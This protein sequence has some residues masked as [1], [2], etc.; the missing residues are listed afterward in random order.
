VKIHI[1]DLSKIYRN[2]TQALDGVNME[3]GTGMYGLLGPNGAGKTTLLRILA[4]LLKPTHG[5]ATVNGF[6]VTDRRQKWMVKQMLGYLPQELGLYPNLTVHEFLN[7]VAILKNLYDTRLRLDALSNAISAAGLEAYA[8][9]R[10]STLSGGMKQRV[11]IAQA[12]LGDPQLL[13]VDEPT[14]GLDPEERVRFRALLA[15]L[16]SDRIVIL[17]TH[18]VED[19]A[20]SCRDMAVL[21]K[22]R[23]R[24]KG[25]PN[26]LIRS[27]ARHTWHAELPADVEPDPQWR[28]VSRVQEGDRL[29][30]RIVGPRPFEAAQPVQPTLEE[31]YLVLMA[32]SA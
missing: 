6:D 15:K 17:S 22:G 27:A 10:I 9:Q 8:N 5:R 11:G 12:L 3:I 7:Y 14:A 19:I 13:I 25:S 30:L 26:Q 18:I 24:F 28:V 2:G 32:R 20:T 21:D 29:H 23:V 16:A 31:A 4:T 1:Q